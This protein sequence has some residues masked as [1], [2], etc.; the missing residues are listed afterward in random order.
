MR[1]RASLASWE[2]VRLFFAIDLDD[3][4]RAAA[5][6]VIASLA[7][8]A[9]ASGASIRWVEPAGLHVTLAFLGEVPDERAAALVDLGAVPLRHAPFALSLSVAGVFPPSGAPRVIWIGPGQGGDEVKRVA[10]LLW[11]RLDGAGYGTGP[12]RFEPHVTLGRVRRARA[13]AA[14]RL[15]SLV[16]GSRPPEIGWTVDRLSLYESRLGSGG[17]T[18]HRLATAALRD[19]GA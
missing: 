12:G 3:H 1:R 16:A 2:S 5:A 10:R 19:G 13:A 11:G 18:Y 9:A 14:R 8:S 15:R 6:Q 4:A 17:S 7:R